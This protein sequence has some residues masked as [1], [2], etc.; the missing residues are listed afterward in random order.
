MDEAL[1]RY[2][3]LMQQ[4]PQLFGRR[5]RRKLILVQEDLERWSKEHDVR[6][7]VLAETPFYLFLQDLVTFDDGD[8]HPYSR[9]IAKKSLDGQNSVVVLPILASAAG[10][11]VVFVLQERH[12]LGIQILELPRGFA[13]P[14]VSESTQAAKELA[15]ETG[16]MGTPV[17]LGASYTDT[18]STDNRVSF[19]LVEVSERGAPNPEVTERIDDIVELSLAAVREGLGTGEIADGYTIQAI[20]LY[21]RFLTCG[22]PTLR[23]QAQ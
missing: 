23:D 3:E 14:G 1:G 18:G 15:T 20:A 13:E 9:L 8:L 16:C 22:S 19:Y 21:D 2:F 11:D 4:K 5:A 17:F 7:G 12:T 10:K 6:L